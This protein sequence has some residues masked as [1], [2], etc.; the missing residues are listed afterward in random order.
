M[1]V[2]LKRSKGLLSVAVVNLILAGRNDAPVQCNL[3]GESCDRGKSRPSCYWAEQRVCRS[4]KPRFPSHGPCCGCGYGT[5][6]P[7][8][9]ENDISSE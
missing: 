5:Q 7:D 8:L 3:E 4:E 2:I 9:H 6:L 1:T